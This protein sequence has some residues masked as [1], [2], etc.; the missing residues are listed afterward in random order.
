M[1]FS[2]RS[3]TDFPVVHL[4]NSA[5]LGSRN[6]LTV[7]CSRVLSTQKPMWNPR[8][9]FMVSLLLLSVT[10]CSLG[11]APDGLSSARRALSAG[12]TAEAID[13]LESCRRANPGQADVYNLLGIAYGRA[14]DNNRSL[15]MFREFARLNPNRPEAY[16]N[17]G[18]AYLRGG[19]YEQAEA[20]FRQALSLNSEDLNALYN[21]G[22]LLNARHVYTESRPLL[23]RA[24]RLERSSPIC[25]EAAVAAAGSGDRVA[26][27]HILNSTRAP[28][29][30]NAAPWFKLT[31][32]LSFDVGNLIAA[33]R[34]LERALALTSDDDCLYA[35]SLVRLKS[36][37]PALA[38]PLLDRLFKSLPPAEKHVREGTLLATHGAYRQALSLFEQGAIEDPTS[39]DALYNLTVLHLERFKDASAALE[40]AQRA[41]ALKATGEIHDLLGDIYETQ[42][43]Y[44]EALNQYQDAVHSD[45]GNDKFLF[46]LGAE[47]MLHE[48]YEAA[49]QVF[50]SGER[51]FPLA[52]RMYLGLGATQFMRGK[53]TDAVHA[54]LKAVDL[55]PGFEPAYIFLGEASTSSTTRSPEVVAKLAEMAS[56]KPQNFEIQYYYGASL[57]QDTQ[58]QQDLEKASRALAALHRAAALRPRDSRVYYQI[59]EILVRENRYTEAISCYQKSATFDPSFPE[60][61][62]KLG[63]T[64][65]RLGRQE[66]A[67]KTFARHREVMTRAEAGLYHRSSEIQSF[68]LTMKTTR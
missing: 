37:E 44:R 40:S 34:A 10:V 53:T 11:Q 41:L 17:L 67:K 43:H 27:L 47:L 46:D 25:Y 2:H 33:S 49:E 5:A 57:V 35:L 31:G 21:L 60:P 9:Y 19:N 56:K 14:N 1:L 68:V 39:Y 55:D 30:Q 54:F 15:E 4:Y 36:N 22:A 66:D 24:L 50:D 6:L 45:P 26:A 61:L 65:V 64:Y 18:A 58:N 16:N 32:T 42:A 28:T 48:N 3:G 23:D 52:S 63:Q 20:V 29:G 7:H 12:Q 8:T 13:L 38:L 59:G 62:Y 51:R